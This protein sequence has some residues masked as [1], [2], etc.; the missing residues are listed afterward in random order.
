M[1][2]EQ[3]TMVE[4]MELC[5]DGY[6]YLICTDHLTS[7][8]SRIIKNHT[9]G[10]YS[11][12]LWLVNYNEA[13]SQDWIYRRVD[14]KKRYLK[15]KHRVKIW[16]ING[17]GHRNIIEW[18]IQNRLVSPVRRRLYDWLGIIG[19]FVGW[20]TLHMRTRMY[21]SESVGYALHSVSSFDIKKPTPMQIN[22]WCEEHQEEVTCIGVFEPIYGVWKEQKDG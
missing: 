3:L 14:F 8:F 4:I 2:W 1:S 7:W 15:G 19:H 13:V 18:F 12:V 20:K 6:P 17:E 21:C 22:Q 5:K 10:E 9:K 11:H 16:K